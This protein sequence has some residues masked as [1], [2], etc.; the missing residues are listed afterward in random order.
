MAV[1]QQRCGTPASQPYPHVVEVLD[2]LHAHGV[3]LAVIAN[4]ERRYTDTVLRAHQLQG[5]FDLV[6]SGD[7]LATKKPDPAG[8]AH[9]LSHFGVRSDQSLFVGDSSIDAATARSAGVPV[10]LLPYGYNMG[11]PI[12]ACGPDRVIA[13]MRP[14][15]A[16]L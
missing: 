12:A 15:L 16:L 4:K 2:R 11:Q 9:C 8:I 1:Y 13:D 5:H 10:W 6:I 7:T 14:V 3:H